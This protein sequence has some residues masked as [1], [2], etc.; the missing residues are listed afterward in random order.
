MGNAGDGLP[1]IGVAGDARLGLAGA[2]WATARAAAVRPEAEP[3][4]TAGAA[5]VRV[6]TGACRRARRCT[7]GRHA[8][9]DAPAMSALELQ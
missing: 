5:T 1:R 9:D 8:G 4:A 3:A 6:R 7:T 2:A